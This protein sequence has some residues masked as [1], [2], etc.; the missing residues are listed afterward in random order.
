MRG[1]GHEAELRRAGKGDL[2]SRYYILTCLLVLGY[3][4]SRFDVCGGAAEGGIAGRLN[5]PTSIAS[6]CMSS[7]Y[8][9]C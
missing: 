2:P 8:Q 1:G 3:V 5:I 4:R 6:C 7:V 9:H